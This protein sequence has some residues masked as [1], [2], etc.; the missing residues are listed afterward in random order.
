MHVTRV[1]CVVMSLALGL[2][3]VLG[4]STGTMAQTATVFIN[5]VDADTPGADALEFVEL[6]DGG[7]GHTPLDGLVLVFYN[8]SN[9]QSYDAFHTLAATAWVE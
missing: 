9:D 5:E 6:Y 1:S 8:G 3:L 7:V 2:A 4:S